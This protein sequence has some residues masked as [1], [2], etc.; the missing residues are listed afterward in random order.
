MVECS[1]KHLQ[2]KKSPRNLFSGCISM[3]LS[4]PLSPAHHFCCLG[5]LLAWSDTRNIWCGQIS[6]SEMQNWTIG[7][8]LAWK[9]LTSLWTLTNSKTRLEQLDPSSSKSLNN[10]NTSK[11]WSKWQKNTVFPEIFS[12]CSHYPKLINIFVRWTYLILSSHLRLSA[13][14]V[15]HD[16]AGCLTQLREIKIASSKIIFTIWAPH[17]LWLILLSLKSRWWFLYTLHFSFRCN[18]I[19]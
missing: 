13:V 6:N 4:L 16:T 5:F 19:F 2:N 11:Q 9:I 17:E 14:A 3:H 18:R 12:K 10:N 8:T 7:N 1:W 15:W